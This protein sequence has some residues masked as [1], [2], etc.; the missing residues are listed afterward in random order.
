MTKEISY[1]YKSINY[2]NPDVL[3]Y[4]KSHQ[5]FYNKLQKFDAGIEY[6][7]FNEFI[8][9][10]ADD[11]KNSGDGVTYIVW[12]ITYDNNSHEIDR[13]I[14]AYYTLAATSIPY[15]DRIRLD[16]NEAIEKGQEFDIEICGISALEIK[17]FA[18]TKKYQDVFFEYD[19]ENLPISAWIMKNII[20]NA[21][22]IS[23]S[24][25]AFKAIF[26]HSIPSA[27]NFYKRNGFNPVEINMQPLYC[28]DSEYSAMYL[29][30]K[31]IHMN[32]DD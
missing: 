7:N 3:S 8:L 13:E 24:I 17:M 6:K 11:Y 29:T 20:D 18:V 26:L 4:E 2:F 9:K 14:V 23:D 21:N 22:E 15:E 25:L 10:E 30:L 32:Y 16:K 12:N 31:E 1:K 28:I 5:D 27:V 19:G